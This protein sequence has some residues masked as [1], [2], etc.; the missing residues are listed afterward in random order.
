M[1]I[2]KDEGN[3]M[4]LSLDLKARVR[5]SNV[6]RKVIP[7]KEKTRGKGSCVHYNSRTSSYKGESIVCRLGYWF[8]SGSCT[9]KLAVSRITGKKVNILIDFLPQNG[10]FICRIS[11]L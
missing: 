4:S 6:C 10:D 2:I 3:K 11:W 1:A 7:E 9:G 5:L 8:A